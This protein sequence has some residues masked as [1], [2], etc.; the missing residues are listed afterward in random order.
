MSSQSQ[1]ANAHLRDFQ[2][3]YETRNPESKAQHE[4]AARHLPGGNTRSVLHGPPFPLCMASGQ[5]NKLVD[6]D[7]HEYVRL[8]AIQTKCSFGLDTVISWVT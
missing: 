4:R 3:R 7:G 5:G 2:Q 8:T 1:L 6:I